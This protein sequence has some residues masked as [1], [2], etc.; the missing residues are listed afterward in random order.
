MAAG[1]DDSNCAQLLA[2]P[3]ASD[4][5]AEIRRAALL[6]NVD[7]AGQFGDLE[8]ARMCGKAGSP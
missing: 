5:L 8:I 3:F 2:S 7:Y 4:L 6:P 1:P